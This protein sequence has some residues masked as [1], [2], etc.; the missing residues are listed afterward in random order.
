MQQNNADQDDL[1]GPGGAA[2]PSPEQVQYYGRVSR[3]YREAI[4]HQLPLIQVR[5]LS[6]L[7]LASLSS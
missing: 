7:L 6:L 1:Y 2:L 4:V 3:L 5:P